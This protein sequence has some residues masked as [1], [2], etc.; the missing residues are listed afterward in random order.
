MET[1]SDKNEESSGKLLTHFSLYL[2]R[3]FSSYFFS[4]LTYLV[5]IEWKKTCCWLSFFIKTLKFSK[6]VADIS[7]AQE[8]QDSTNFSGI[9]QPRI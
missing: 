8:I 6:L 9:F 3:I 5:L 4:F 2:Y 7:I 1:C